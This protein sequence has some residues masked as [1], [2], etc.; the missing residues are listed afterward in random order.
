MYN[1]FKTFQNHR[2][3]YSIYFLI[4]ELNHFYH[5]ILKMHLNLYMFIVMGHFVRNLFLIMMLILKIIIDFFWLNNGNL[6]LHVH[7]FFIFRA[8]FHYTLTINPSM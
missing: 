7:F 5:L 8:T 2:S 3:F 6:N 4:L 1:L